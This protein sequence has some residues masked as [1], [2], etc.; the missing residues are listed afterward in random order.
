MKC[1][2][3]QLAVDELCQQCGNCIVCCECEDELET[4]D[5]S[6]DND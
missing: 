1:P 4:T 2:Q 5:F 6:D 3:C